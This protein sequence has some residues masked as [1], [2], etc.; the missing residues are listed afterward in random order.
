MY[1]KVKLFLQRKLCHASLTRFCSCVPVVI[2]FLQALTAIPIIVIQKIFTDLKF[3]SFIETQRRPLSLVKKDIILN[4]I[5]SFLL[6]YFCC[7]LLLISS[8][9]NEVKLNKTYACLFNLTHILACRP[10]IY[11]LEMNTYRRT[12]FVRLHTVYKEI[13]I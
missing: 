13:E 2:Y 9:A 6:P 4:T 10:S 1:E 8:F 11:I 7:Y 3:Q 12:D 5:V